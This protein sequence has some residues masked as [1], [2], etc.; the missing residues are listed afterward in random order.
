MKKQLY[1]VE[2]VAGM[3]HYHLSETGCSGQLA[4]CGNR[5]VMCT[6]LRL[7]SWGSCGHLNERY[8]RQCEAA[9]N[10][11]EGQPHFAQQAAAQN[12]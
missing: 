2:G 11:M 10:A 1:V 6:E 12:G 5:R 8:C 3:W 4:L 9:A 7:S